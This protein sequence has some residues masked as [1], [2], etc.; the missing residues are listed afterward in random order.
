[1]KNDSGPTTIEYGLLASLLYVVIVVAV[2]A[3][4]AGGIVN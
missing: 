2:K 1:M 3:I 4:G